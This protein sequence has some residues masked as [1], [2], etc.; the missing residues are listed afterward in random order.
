MQ[1]L[2]TWRPEARALSRQAL[3]PP[4]PRGRPL[5]P[6]LP[7]R[8]PRRH[9]CRRGFRSPQPTPPYLVD[10]FHA[11]SFAPLHLKTSL[12]V[13][14]PLHPYLGPRIRETNS[15]DHP[16]SIAVRR[17]HTAVTLEIP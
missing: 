1:R 9:Q 12:G 17:L 2:Q 13:I 8:P 16:S 14:R 6:P 11:H 5:L 10:L 7:Q 15:R 4:D 3:S